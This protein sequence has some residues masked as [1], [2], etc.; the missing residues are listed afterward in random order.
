[1]GRKTHVA[2][3]VITLGALCLLLLRILVPEVKVDAVSLGLFILAALPWLSDLIKSADLPGGLGVTFRDIK[4]AGDK[5]VESAGQQAGT[6]TGSAPESLDGDPNLALVG[7]RIDIERRLR[8]LA[9][10]HG[11][12]GHQPLPDLVEELRGLGLLNGR[13]PQGL[14]ELIAAGNRAAHGA[15]VEPAVKDWA[16][17]QGPRILRFLDA[18]LEGPPSGDEDTWA[19]GVSS[20]E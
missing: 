8:R 7:L 4:D 11:L 12:Q 6:R 15:R 3:V 13:A 20:Q 10:R 16:I 14:S 9:A 5:V 2:K 19:G 18:K 17:S 1:M